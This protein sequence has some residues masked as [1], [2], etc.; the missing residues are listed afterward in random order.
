MN[1]EERRQAEEL[2]KQRDDDTRRRMDA[3]VELTP[4]EQLREAVRH[5]MERQEYEASRGLSAPT[6]GGSGKTVA[7]GIV[8]VGAAALGIATVFLFASDHVALA[9]VVGSIA[10]LL[11]FW[12]FYDRLA[13]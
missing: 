11:G 2:M 12:G 9:A 8:L 6:Q 10:L 4:Q 5:S 1:E 7:T 3:H 13:S